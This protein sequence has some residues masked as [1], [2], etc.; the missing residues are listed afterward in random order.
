MK[1][2]SSR[3][4]TEEEILLVHDPN[5]VIAMKNVVKNVHKLNE[6]A[7]NFN[8][9]YFHPKTFECATLAAGSVLQ[10]VD[11]V[12]NLQCRS[13]VCVIRPPGH[14][15]EPDQPQGFCIFN[16]IAIAAE[17]AIKAHG[18]KRYLFFCALLYHILNKVINIL[19]Y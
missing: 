11:N 12:L 13:G 3:H 18:L 6:L 2:V 5:H 7:D 17:Y 4:A 1:E 10:M 14:H 15:A 19:G 9:V 8:S 16:N